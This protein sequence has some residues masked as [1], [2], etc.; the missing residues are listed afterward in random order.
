M[1]GK[2]IMKHFHTLTQGWKSEQDIKLRKTTWIIRVVCIQRF[3]CDWQK[4]IAYLNSAWKST[5]GK[6]VYSTETFSL[7]NSVDLYQQNFIYLSNRITFLS[8]EQ[9]WLG[10]ILRFYINVSLLLD[11]CADRNY[12]S[13]THSI[14][15]YKQS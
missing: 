1:Q 12:R 3:W 11:R 4:Q 7:P 10:I 9:H 8:V 13:I 15:F 5:S 14:W 6:L 2:M